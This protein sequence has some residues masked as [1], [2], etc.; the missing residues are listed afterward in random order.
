MRHFAA[1][2]VNNTLPL[3]RTGP[4]DSSLQGTVAELAVHTAAVLLCGQGDILEPLK[5][6]A[7]SPADMVVRPAG[8]RRLGGWHLWRP[9]PG[10]LLKVSVSRLL[11]WPV[12]HL[13]PKSTVT[14]SL[15]LFAPW[16]PWR[17]TRGR[18]QSPP[19]AQGSGSWPN[20][21]PSGSLLSFSAF[22]NSYLPTMPEDLLVQAR[23]W[24]GLETLSWYSECRGLRRCHILCALT[25][26]PWFVP[27]GPRCLPCSAVGAFA[28]TGRTADCGGRTPGPS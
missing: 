1:S 14:E 26:L 15:V 24:K 27:K 6:L 7:F 18:V 20:L 5:S 19:V 12:S 25:R 3:L 8:G 9:V 28:D 21:S 11:S 10:A 4:R 13:I 17:W 23:N 2:L 22:Q 16:R